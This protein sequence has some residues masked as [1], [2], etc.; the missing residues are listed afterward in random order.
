MKRIKKGGFNIDY[1]Y[2]RWTIIGNCF[3]LFLTGSLLIFHFFF[4]PFFPS[5]LL[6]LSVSCSLLLSFIICT[7]FISIV[8]ASYSTTFSSN[9]AKRKNTRKKRRRGKIT[10]KNADCHSILCN[11]F[12]NT[13]RTHYKN[14]IRR[15]NAS[16]K[17]DEEKSSDAACALFYV[18][19][20]HQFFSHSG[21]FSTKKTNTVFFPYS[22]QRWRYLIFSLLFIT[23]NYIRL[24]TLF[25]LYST[26]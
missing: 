7:P 18:N 8:N 12:S 4:I 9:E 2:I 15:T 11:K 14:K 1:I 24:I 26:E 3:S 22:A 19:E 16:V 20:E 23:M 6:S 17:S 5:A 13:T 10:Q 21:W 25:S